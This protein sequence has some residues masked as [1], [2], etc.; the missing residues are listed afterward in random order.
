MNAVRWFGIYRADEALESLDE[1]TRKV[2][3][4]IGWNEICL[5]ENIDT[6]RAHFIKLYDQYRERKLEEK[7]M[8][9][10]ALADKITKLLNGKNKDVLTEKQKYAL[11]DGKGGSQ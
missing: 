10:K 7:L 9:K 2:V 3:E 4:A 11:R 5:T 1:T 6:V 8:D